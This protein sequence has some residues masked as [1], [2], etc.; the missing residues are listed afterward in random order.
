MGFASQCVRLPCGSGRSCK[1]GNAGKVIAVTNGNHDVN[2]GG[3]NCIVH[4]WLGGIRSVGK[5]CG[6]RTWLPPLTLSPEVNQPAGIIPRHIALRSPVQIS[7]AGRKYEQ[8]RWLFLAA[9]ISAGTSAD[10]LLGPAMQGSARPRAAQ[11]GHR[12]ASRLVPPASELN[13]CTRTVANATIPLL[14]SI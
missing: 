2:G 1:R 3:D 11:L 14:I 9:R 10:P 12:A 8:N 5:P 6:I 13:L 7:R 4:K